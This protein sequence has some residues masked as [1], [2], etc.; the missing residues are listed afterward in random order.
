MIALIL[1]G[2]LVGGVLLAYPRVDRHA[3]GWELVA[4]TSVVP[5][6]GWRPGDPDEIYY[7]KVG[8]CILL[9][10]GLFL[11]LSPL[12]RLVGNE[13]RLKW[14]NPAAPGWRLLAIAS[15]AILALVLLVYPAA[16]QYFTGGGP[17]W[18]GYTGSQ[19]SAD[20]F[21]LNSSG[22][23]ARVQVW[24]DHR[25]VW[26]TTIPALKASFDTSSWKLGPNPFASK[27]VQISYPPPRKLY[28]EETEFLKFRR[29]FTLSRF[30]RRYGG[31][32]VVRI[33][34]R[35]IFFE[36]AELPTD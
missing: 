16:L 12:S 5:I 19:G 9:W 23:E 27:Q 1:A 6:L 25:Q 32:Y 11:A 18:Q 31:Q 35:E 13:I 20:L 15:P 34:R 26:D 29:T 21:I 17:R 30:G 2:A 14:K 10:T 24:F 28:V 3:E 7:I 4:R 22:R 33:G 8:V 36:F